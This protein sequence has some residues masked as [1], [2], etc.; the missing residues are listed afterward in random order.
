[1]ASGYSPKWLRMLYH[2]PRLFLDCPA[3]NKHWRWDTTCRCLVGTN[4][5]RPY[6][7]TGAGFW[8]EEPVAEEQR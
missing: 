1:M 8:V 2:V 7:Y 4:A 3:G 6:H 5:H